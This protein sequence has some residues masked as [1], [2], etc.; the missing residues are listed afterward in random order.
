MVMTAQQM[1]ELFVKQNPAAANCTYDAWSYGDAPDELAELTRRGIK[2]A[3]ASA[4]PIYA[5]EGE[6][7]PEAGDYNV[8]LDSKGSAVCI[9]RTE[10]VFV[11]PFREV[12]EVQAFREGEGDRSLDYWR[13]VHRR[14]FTEELAA[15][16]MEFSEDMGVV[17]EEF[18]VVFSL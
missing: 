9:T 18:E 3:T 14:F 7:L 2:S 8:I 12:T 11:L 1:W 10:R 13:E 6:P 17:C 16:D 5:L 4:Y 15:Y